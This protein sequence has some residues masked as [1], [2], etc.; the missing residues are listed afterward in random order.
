MVEKAAAASEED[1]W[2][3]VDDRAQ[4]GCLRRRLGKFEFIA[5]ELLH[6]LAG[7]V[8]PP[9]SQFYPGRAAQRKGRCERS[10]Q[11]SDWR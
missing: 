6:G 9:P 8:C 4:L 1:D 11:H 2:D 7:K 5:A 3:A 10:D